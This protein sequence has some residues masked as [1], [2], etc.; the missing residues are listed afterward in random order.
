MNVLIL[1]GSPRLQGNTAEL[2]KPFME[3]LRANGADVRYMTLA[4]KNI[5]PCKGCYACQ[6]VERLCQHANLIYAGLWS[7]RDEDDLASFQ[8]PA[9]MEGARAFAR[10]LL[11]S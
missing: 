2:T 7:V 5:G 10:K 11:R 8:T 9:A 6:Y 4:D 1:M 3:E